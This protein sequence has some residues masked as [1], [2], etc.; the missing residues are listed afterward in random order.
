MTIVRNFA[1]TAAYISATGQYPAA[2][3]TGLASSATTDTTNATN[4]NT[5][6]LPT[7]QLSGSYTGITGVGTLSAGSIPS[8]LISG[9]TTP[10][11]NAQVFYQSGTWTAPTGVTKVSAKLIGGGG[12]GASNGAGGGTTAAAGGQGGS[13]FAIIPV[14][15]GTAYTVTVGA[16]GTGTG[17]DGGGGGGTGTGTGGTGGTTSFGSLASVTGGTGGYVTGNNSGVTQGAKGSA[18]LS[19]G[20]LIKQNI[21][22]I[23][24]L[25]SAVP[26]SLTTQTGAYASNTAYTAGYPGST[27]VIFSNSVFTTY[28][29][30]GIGGAVLLEW[31]G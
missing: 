30:A 29:Q 17:N 7:A 2:N 20:T 3:V 12:G 24:L 9:L 25:E 22:V 31:I 13:L 1:N 5:G 28:G 21:P 23:N 10:Q 14:T 6:T 16:G 27:Y 19:S 8:S 18:T 15:P 4:I 11:L 26:N